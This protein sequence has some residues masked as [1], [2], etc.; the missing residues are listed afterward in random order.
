[1]NTDLNQKHHEENYNLTSNLT[2]SLSKLQLNLTKNIHYEEFINIQNLNDNQKIYLK[3]LAGHLV[4]D[5]MN[6]R[7]MVKTNFL[8]V[9]K[10]NLK[11][12]LQHKKFCPIFFKFFYR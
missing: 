2:D 7:E 9:S 11:K 3:N 10:F 5:F 6:Y 1:M 12:N 8:K 4:A